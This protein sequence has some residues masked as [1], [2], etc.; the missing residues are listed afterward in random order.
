LNSKWEDGVN[1]SSL[2]ERFSHRHV[3]VTFILA[4]TDESE[5]TVRGK[6]VACPK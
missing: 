5:L 4:C 1:Q 2:S 3:F 6:N